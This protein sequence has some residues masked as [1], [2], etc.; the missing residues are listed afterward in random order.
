[1]DSEQYQVIYIDNER[2]R[3]NGWY[4]K[5][6]EYDYYWLKWTDCTM[7]EISFCPFCGEELK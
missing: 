2:Y 3:K 5:K 7:F 6:R 4:L 1:M